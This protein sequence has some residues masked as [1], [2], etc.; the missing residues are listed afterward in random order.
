MED[1]D[2]RLETAT[3]R[4]DTLSGA[5]QRIE[6]KLESARKTKTTLEET[7]RS[8][9]VEPDQIETVIQQLTTRYETAVAQIETDIKAADKALA[10]YL[11]ES[12]D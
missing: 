5:V 7:C 3:K 1:L 11:N 4:R 6:G 8:K 12:G 2:N 10:P 9:G